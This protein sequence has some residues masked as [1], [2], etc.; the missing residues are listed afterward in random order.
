MENEFAQAAHHASLDPRQLVESAVQGD[1]GAW[2]EIYLKHYDAIY[3]Y[4]F[5]RLG[6]KEEAED[7]ASQVFLEALKSIASYKDRGKPLAAWLFGIARNVSNNQFRHPR[8][9]KTESLNRDDLMD[10]NVV[11][12]DHH[13]E[14]MDLMAGINLL[15]EDQRETII[16]RFYVGLSAKEA[17]GILGKSEHAIYA[18]QVR[19]IA[20]LRR[21]LTLD[22]Q[23]SA[24]SA[25]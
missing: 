22:V 13:A 3:R 21:R 2:S 20:T 4:L 11:V 1:S 23:P 7:L 10:G 16:L 9:T 18:L 12:P 8:R 15:T 17:A 14:M 5:G 19:A 24:Q 6:R 25:A